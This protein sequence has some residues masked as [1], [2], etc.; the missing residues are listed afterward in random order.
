[1]YIHDPNES[2]LHEQVAHD[3]DDRLNAVNVQMYA[4]STSPEYADLALKFE[5]LT[6]RQAERMAQLEQQ[7]NTTTIYIINHQQEQTELQHQHALDALQHAQEMFDEM[8]ARHRMI[9]QRLDDQLQQLRERQQIINERLNH[10]Q[11]DTE[12]VTHVFDDTDV[13]EDLFDINTS[14]ATDE[15]STTT[16]YTITNDDGEVSGTV[17]VTTS[18]N[19]DHNVQVW[20]DDDGGVIINSSVN[21]TGSSVRIDND[22]HI[23][24][25]STQ[26]IR[27]NGEDIR[28]D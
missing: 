3:L 7:L 6:R 10:L 28:F 4:A 14:T 1:M 24:S 18:G 20:M 5:E 16:V 22:T 21:A 8:D 15:H 23:E 17:E 19:D 9:Q 13:L 11:Q 25:R 12:A 2:V 26:R 27:I